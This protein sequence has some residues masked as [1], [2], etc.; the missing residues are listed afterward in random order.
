M[1]HPSYSYENLVLGL[2][3]SA[4]DGHIAVKVSTGPLVNLAH[5]AS[6]SRATGLLVL[7]EF[8]RGNAAAILGDSLALLDSDKRSDIASGR[9]GAVVDLPY[10]DMDIQVPEEFAP[11]GNRNVSSRFSLPKSLWIV[12]A[13][14]SSDRSVAPLDAAM[15]RRF[16][17][18][19]VMPDYEALRSQIGATESELPVENTDWEVNDVLNLSV[20]L[21]KRLNKRIESIIGPDFMLGQSQFWH[22]AG[23]EVDNVLASLSRA[24]DEGVVPTLQMMFTDYDE[25]LATILK[26]DSSENASTSPVYNSLCYWS[27][28]DEDLGAVGYPRLRFNLLSTMNSD[29][30]LHELK[31]LTGV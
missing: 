24:M 7:D 5:Y 28:P 16:A 2:L 14:N 1:L 6:E 27:R 30:A 20:L 3:P 15:R 17:I 19:N 4:R 10:S 23:H 8:N 29:N 25:A 11:N 31:R 18:V 21:L 9:E 22:V 12:A 26:A 13:M